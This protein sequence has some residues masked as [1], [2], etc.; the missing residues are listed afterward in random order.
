MSRSRGLALAKSVNQITTVVGGARAPFKAAGLA[1]EA[2]LE[3]PSGVAVDDQG[4]VYVA[5]DKVVTFSPDGKQIGLFG[6]KERA[7]NIAF[8]MPDGHMLFVTAMGM[9]YRAQWS[10]KGLN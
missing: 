8:G 5:A 1:S 3:G 9:V 4:N 2:I 6:V 10:V 7:S